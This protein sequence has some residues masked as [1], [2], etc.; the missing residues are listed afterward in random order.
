MI[1]RAVCLFMVGCSFDPS[2]VSPLKDDDATTMSDAGPGTDAAPPDAPVCV[3]VAE[4]CNKLDDDCDGE[5]DN[6]FESMT[7]PDCATETM[8]LGT[9]SG[10]T[11]SPALMI[12]GRGE[13]YVRVRVTE[14]SSSNRSLTGRASLYLNVA[15]LQTETDVRLHSG[16]DCGNGPVSDDGFLF[17][18]PASPEVVPIAK[19]DSSSDDDYDVILNVRILADLRFCEDWVL[20][21]EGDTGDD[22]VTYCD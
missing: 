18:D 5:V 12:S 10:D 3:A 11:S 19:N 21:V 14:D 20:V 8:F 7:G 17:A 16:C 22:A 6:G 2:G 15:E 13:A 1:E 4:T 9:I